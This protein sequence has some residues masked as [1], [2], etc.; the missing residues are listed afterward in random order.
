MPSR[1]DDVIIKCPYFRSMD[2]RK[3]RCYI[4]CDG[5]MQDIG[6]QM[7]FADR[8]TRQRHTLRYC[9][10]DHWN[11]PACMAIDFWYEGEQ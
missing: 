5:G 4:T 6:I 1:W 11:C 10:G 7:M 8:E 9:A 2:E 3:P